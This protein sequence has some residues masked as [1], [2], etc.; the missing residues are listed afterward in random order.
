[1]VI[2]HEISWEITEIS[3]ESRWIQRPWRLKVVTTRWCLVGEISQAW[4]ECRWNMIIRQG[5]TWNITPLRWL[6]FFGIPPRL[7]LASSWFPLLPQGDVRAALEV[8]QEIRR[9]T[10]DLGKP[11]K[12]AETQLGRTCESLTAFVL[13]ARYATRPG[14]P[15]GQGPY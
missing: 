3:S 9:L 13:R 2:H 8:A 11:S 6:L 15:Q 10:K 14:P 5:T 12:E 7:G 4:P 1:M